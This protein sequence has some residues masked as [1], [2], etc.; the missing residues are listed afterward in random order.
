LGGERGVYLSPGHAP[1]SFGHN[2][3]LL[4]LSQERPIIALH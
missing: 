3:K 4:K 1:L 2:A